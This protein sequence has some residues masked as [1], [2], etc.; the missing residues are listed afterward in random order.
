MNLLFVQATCRA[1]AFALFAA[2]AA[3][4]AISTA[5]ASTCPFDGGGSDAMNDG[6]VLTRYALEITGSPMIASTRYA[7][8]DPLQVK[9]NIECVGCALDMNGDSKIDTVDTT[10]IAR[11]L[12]GFTGESLTAGLSLGTAP[13]ATRTDTAAI[14]S[15]LANGC[16]SSS[17]PLA[18]LNGGNSFAN[19]NAVLGPIGAAT[20][21]IGHVNIVDSA[22]VVN[23]IRIFS[24][25]NLLTNYS[26]NIVGGSRGNGF[27]DGVIGATLFGGQKGNIEG[28]GP[29]RVFG[30]YGTVSGGHNN[31]AGSFDASATDSDRATVAGG[32]SNGAVARGSA[33][34]GGQSN[35][36]SGLNSVISGGNN[37]Q[38]SA[39]AA[40]V[41]GGSL[42]VASGIVSSVHGGAENVSSGYGSAVAGG[43]N[44]QTTNT[45]SFAAGAANRSSGFT[46]FALGSGS[47]A[48]ASVSFALG[49]YAS[50]MHDYAF[51]WGGNENGPTNSAGPS[52][53]TAF[54][55]NGY[56]FYGGTSAGKA[57]IYVPDANNGWQCTSDRNAKTNITK[58]DGKSV[59]A[60]V[61]SMPVS[62]WS[63][64]GGEAF[65]QIGPMAQDFFA[66][67]KLG[68]DDKSI[69][70]MNMSGVALAAIQGLNAKL[71]EEVKA[72]NADIKR[73]NDEI[74][75]IKKKLGM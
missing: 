50:A 40:T 44:N 14:T 56:Y 68:N 42:N 11:H 8:L 6:L 57:C 20:F 37:N 36:S 19:P 43:Y 25:P 66:A 1:F 4:T 49:R 17:N 41:S 60:K 73:L 32:W 3:T 45:F 62:S 39:V 28:V 35:F 31:T 70:P 15:F 75:A 21:D 51:V 22:Y 46:S 59:L 52:T 72:K 64:I 67:F 71:M 29:N 34:G 38:A 16:A 23:G 27:G 24:N 13:A 53:F 74:V 33:I 47:N 54:A 30:N 69:S 18:Y 7:S 61:A 58:L 10:I 26:P 2:A 12:A 65:R 63:F 9:N 48:S 5:I 55:Q